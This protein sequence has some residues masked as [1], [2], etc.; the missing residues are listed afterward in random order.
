M[1]YVISGTDLRQVDKYTIDTIGIPALVLME[2]AALTVAEKIISFAKMTDRI[3]VV[4]GTGNNG[5]DGI[6]AARILCN[7]GYN[8]CVYILGHQE[9]GTDEFKLQREIYCKVGGKVLEYKA[10]CYETNSEKKFNEIFNGTVC[11]DSR[12]IEA[13]IIVDAI[14]GVGLSRNVEGVYKVAI[15]IINAVPAKVVAVDIPSGIQAD[16]GRVMGVAV[17]ADIT[18]TFGM[19]KTGLIMYPGADFAGDIVIADIGFPKYV[20]D[21]YFRYKVLESDDFDLIPRRN[22]DSNKGSYGKLLVIA[23]SEGMIGAA[24]M[25]S[26]AALRM[27][28]GMVRV[29]TTKK[30]AHHL[31]N[32][33]PEVMLTTY[34]DIDYEEKLMSVMKWCDAIAVGPGMGTGT[35]NENII[36]I[37]LRSKLPSVIDADG[38]NCISTCMDLK[39]LLHNKVIITPHIGEMSRF[40]G[41]SIKEIKENAF[42]VAKNNAK[43]YN[44]TVVLKDARTVISD[45]EEIYINI[46]GNNGMATAGSGDVLTGITLSLIGKGME[47]TTAGSMAAYIHGMA[48]DMAAA[49]LSKTSLMATDIIDEI[50]NITKLI[51]Q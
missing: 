40:T 51:E 11:N 43:K 26:K 46:T 24:Y 49:G 39:E 14:F 50:V 17:H 13:D 20:F 6:A 5:A 37:V 44:I 30:V 48:G 27:G 42:N 29:F 36:R 38:V 2:R 25:C 28:A 32:S 47:I 4:C 3:V 16:N 31:S 41:L 8:T 23:G 19:Q 35:L 10:E 34:T 9:K 1:K 21:K 15:D 33:L 18:V 7:K 22:N 12:R 45:G